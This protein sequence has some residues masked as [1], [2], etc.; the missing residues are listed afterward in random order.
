MAR[1]RIFGLLALSLA[2]LACADLLGL[3]PGMLG[4]D[5]GASAVAGNGGIGSGSTGNGGTTSDSGTTSNGGS[6]GSS[7]PNAGNAGADLGGAD[8]GGAGGEPSTP[9]GGEPN[10]GPCK[11]GICTRCADDMHRIISNAGDFYCIDDGEVTN[12]DYLAFTQRYTVDTVI[13]TTECGA[14]T[15]LVPDT[16]CSDALTD[17]PSKNL[18]V[19][20]VDFCDAQA[21]CMMRGRR[22][23][24]RVGGVMNNPGDDA[25]AIASEWYGACAGPDE[26]TYPYGNSA[27]ATAC[28]GSAYSPADMG[29]RDLATM[30]DC[31]GTSGIYNLSGNVAEWEWSCSSSKANAICSTRGGSFKDGPYELRCTSSVGRNRLDFADDLG[32]RCCAGL[33]L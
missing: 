23:C 26:T 14:N 1:V 27:S 9:D 30:S 6:A 24:G 20:C 7:L 5:A 29:P 32:F 4:A 28:N 33:D 10:N 13:A 3:Q 2:P 21:Y 11:N 12:A 17:V 19:V 18:P 8:G 15:S 25:N 16:A 22:L 31:R